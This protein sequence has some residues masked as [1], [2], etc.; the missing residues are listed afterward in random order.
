[1][2]FSY[3]SGRRFGA[4]RTAGFRIPAAAIALLAFGLTACDSEKVLEVQD[5]D[6]ATP[7]SLEGAAALGV[8]HAGAIGDFQLGYSGSSADEGQIQA[9]AWLADEYI[10]SETFPTRIEVDQRSV[11]EENGT[12]NEIMREIQR[13]R[14]SSDFASDKFGTSA[15]TDIRRAE[16]M[17][18]AGFAIDIMGENYC[19]GVPFSRLLPTGEIVFGE[20]RTTVQ[21]WDD[22]IAK[23]DSAQAVIAGR[24][25]AAAVTQARLARVGKARAL[26]NKGDFAGAAAAI[27]G[28][29]GVPTSFSYLIFHSVNT[30]RQNNG[31]WVFQHV[32]S[33]FSA[34]DREG[35]N[36]LPFRS[37]NDP[38]TP[39]SRAGGAGVGFD[40]I[41]PLFFV[42]KYP[43]RDSPAELAGGIEARLIEAEAALRAGD[44]VGAFATLNALRAMQPSLAPLV[45]AATTAG[46][47]D[48]LFKERAYWLWFTSHRLGDLRRLIRQYGRTE[49]QVF[50]TGSYFKGGVYGDDVNFIIPLDERNNPN[51]Q[52]C[53]DRNA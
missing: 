16:T 50:P 21:M 38:R 43:D 28:T 47:V 10:N 5:P 20:Q 49:D 8:V 31:I 9:S 34:A 51:F 37:D 35:G 44:V 23:F 13:A 25:T 19:S 39:T 22:A 18:L 26:L 3:D 7:P 40:N 6:V 32:A 48:Q 14:A 17:N 12:M 15:P 1:M 30:S 11:T 46:Q 45:P 41:T 53:L 42:D 27:G 36:G 29:A 52:G 24:T 2:S 33:R 4:G